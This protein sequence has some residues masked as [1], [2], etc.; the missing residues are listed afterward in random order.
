VDLEFGS[1]SEG[2]TAVGPNKFRYA[3]G[4]VTG[5]EVEGLQDCV[6]ADVSA[7]VNYNSP[8]GA[9]KT[10]VRCSS[11]AFSFSQPLTVKWLLRYKPASIASFKPN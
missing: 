9:M 11:P 10:S 5:F 2:A 3:S 7:D 8:G 6:V 1:F 4:D